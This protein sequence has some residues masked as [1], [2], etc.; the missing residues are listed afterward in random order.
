M[1]EWMNERKDEWINKGCALTGPCTMAIIELL[2][3]L[4]WLA[5]QQSYTLN[6]V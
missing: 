3:V 5:P 1:S 6:K 2:Y 4:L